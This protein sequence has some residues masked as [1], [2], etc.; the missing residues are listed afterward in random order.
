MGMP[1]APPPPG[2]V[3]PPFG[4]GEAPPGTLP[5]PAYR[6]LYQQ[7]TA[8]YG[9]VDALREAVNAPFRTFTATDAWLGPEA[10]AWGAELGSNRRRLQSAADKI[11]WS[12]YNRVRATPRFLTPG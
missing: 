7:Y 2:S 5:N 12:I 9:S 1:S 6:E 8:A 4:T 10:R 3:P 11:L